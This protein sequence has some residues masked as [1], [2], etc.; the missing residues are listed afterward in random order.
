VPTSLIGAI[1]FGTC[2]IF[3]GS[4]TQGWTQVTFLNPGRL[5]PRFGTDE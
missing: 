1:H 5:D 2:W 4:C 3:Q